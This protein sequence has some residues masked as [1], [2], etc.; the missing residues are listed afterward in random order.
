MKEEIDERDDDGLS[1]NQK[2]MEKMPFKM[3][4]NPP[5]NMFRGFFSTLPGLKSDKNKILFEQ[6]SNDSPS[7]PSSV[8]IDNKLSTKLLHY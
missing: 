8:G 6:V 3:Y 1:L 7:E 2:P 4:Y 5:S